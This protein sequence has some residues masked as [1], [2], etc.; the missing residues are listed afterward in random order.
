MANIY[1]A[2]TPN[3]LGVCWTTKSIFTILKSAKQDQYLEYLSIVVA[4]ST[5]KLKNFRYFLEICDFWMCQNKVIHK[6]Q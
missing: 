4:F 2:L 1:L 5:E 6:A 3:I